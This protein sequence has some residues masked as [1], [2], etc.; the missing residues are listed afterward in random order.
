M[1]RYGVN[2]RDFVAGM[3]VAEG[4]LDR[5]RIP[6]MIRY[7]S[8]GLAFV[9]ALAATGCSGDDGEP[10]SPGGDHHEGELSAAAIAELETLADQAVA[11]G[12]P[13]VTLAVVRGRQTVTIARGAAN[14]ADG[15][16]MSTDHH[17]RMASLA[18]SFTA[19]VVLQLVNEGR[20]SLADS[21]GQWLPGLLPASA[22]VTIEQMLRLE[23]GLFDFSADD[24]YVG[25]LLAGDW[26]HPYTAE[27]LV[28]YASEH[29]PVFAPG[30]RFM[31]SNTNYVALAL[32]VEKITGKPLA[33]V[34]AERITTPLGLTQS[35]FSTGSEL[36]EPSAH[37]YLVGLGEPIDTTSFSGS[38][39]YGC[40]NLVSTPLDVARFYGAL[41]K[42]EVV[43][44]A[45]L[46]GMF[47]QSPGIDTQYGMGVFHFDHSPRFLSC[48]DFI[49]HDGG[50]PGY[51]STGYSSIDGKRQF[52]VVVTSF[53]VEEKA[54]DEKAQQAFGALIDAA[55]CW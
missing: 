25:N 12:I 45:Q 41:A 32:I 24:R 9:I 36:P 19:S 49:G 30:A 44:R 50:I 21:V 26:S 54:G 29:E 46:P 35:S 40:G 7:R 51:D 48:G 17:V 18:K 55:A 16:P 15:E 37:G 34:V 43:S 28:G 52:S 11:A 13:G 38:A 3:T 22:G 6:T 53:T 20:L 2:H 27:E 4:L 23:S 10:S 5:E 47:A 1:A 42:G 8:I 14:A 31:Y 39:V 33:E